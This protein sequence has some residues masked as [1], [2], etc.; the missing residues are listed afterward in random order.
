MN[1]IQKLADI[2][3]AAVILLNSNTHEANYLNAQP[4]DTSNHTINFLLANIQLLSNH[5]Y[6]S[7]NSPWGHILTCQ[8]TNNLIICLSFNYSE[9]SNEL[10]TMH[11][12]SNLKSISQIIYKLYNGKDAPDTDVIITKFSDKQLVKIENNQ[13]FDATL[14]FN[15]E[16]D[17]IKAI[18]YSHNEQL[19]SALEKLSYIKIIGERFAN[20]NFIRGEKDTLISYIAVLNRAIIQWGY[21]I[22]SAFHLHNDLVQEVELSSQF[23]D[24]FQVIREVTWHYF[25]VIKNY[26]VTNFLPLHERIRQYVKEHITE[27]M[28]LDDIATRLNASKKLLNPAFKNEYGITITQFIRQVKI[29]AA[30]ELLI[31]SDLTLLDISNLLSFSTTTYFVKT[32]KEITG[33]TPKYFRQHFFD[34]HLHL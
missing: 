27:S 5:Q 10:M 26:R 33:L 2:L 19:T 11:S 20:T 18:I 29:D 31:A 15:A 9:T 21:P 4:T 6:Q 16:T 32:F 12:L 8:I 3:N 7:L 14:F 22:E 25:N 34:Q 13:P 28:T 24:F 30:K 23:S 1:D 17:I